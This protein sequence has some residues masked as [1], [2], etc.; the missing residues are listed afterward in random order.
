MARARRMANPPRDAPRLADHG[1]RC[2]RLA[3]PRAPPEPVLH[4]RAEPARGPRAS[5]AVALAP[6]RPLPLR[7]WAARAVAG[8]WGPSL[9]RPVG[10]L[11]SGEGSAGSP[12]GA[13]GAVEPRPAVV[14]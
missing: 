7:A 13:E 14:G 11:R 12:R 8:P 9:P 2:G 4:R 3:V 1:S 10:A 6:L 5:E